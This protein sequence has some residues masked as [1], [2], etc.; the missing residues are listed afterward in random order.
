M[1]TD[2]VRFDRVPSEHDEGGFALIMSVVIATVCLILVTSILAMGLHLDSA[3]FRERR[4]QMALQVAEGGVERAVAEVN[5]AAVDDPDA[6]IG[7][8]IATGAGEHP[9]PIDIPGGQFASNVTALAG[10]AGF[11]VDAVG[12]VPD[13]TSPN[14]LMRR[15]RVTFE[16][17]PSFKY[18]LFS[19]TGIEVK[20]DNNQ[21]INGDIFANDD[22]VV[23]QNAEINGSVI[24][25]SGS[26]HIAE[27]VRIQ[28]ATDGTGGSVYSGGVHPADSGPG[29][30]PWGVRLDGNTL[31]ENEVHVQVPT[32]PCS[33]PSENDYNLKFGGNG[34]VVGGSVFVPGSVNGT[35][36][37]GS[38]DDDACEQAFGVTSLPEFTYQESAYPG[39]Q[40]VD[41]DDFTGTVSGYMYVDDLND[42]DAEI[43][44]CSVNG[45]AGDVVLITEARLVRT[46]SCGTFYTGPTD[47]T[48][49]LIVLN[50]N[51]ET[52]TFGPSV[53][54][55][56]N[57][58]LPN[59][60]PA[61]LLYSQGYCDLGTTVINSGAIYCNGLEVQT[62]MYLSYD[63]RI[64]S[65]VGFGGVLFERAA[66]RE[67]IASTPI[68]VTT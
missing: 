59:P 61:L 24:S 41:W 33:S 67:L 22:I 48:I 38:V 57:F 42:P 16:P 54:L 46:N 32:P 39:I 3:T 40:K 23:A 5:R 31:V 15:I 4:W 18:A 6:P 9:T 12:Y 14:R 35:G 27:N 62:N 64:R 66:F 44:L 65:L 30:R 43:D 2:V 21:P 17:E 50:D 52:A 11:Q 7:D 47:R 49:Q 51:G 60:S 68:T 25:A 1:S 29:E 19:N 58:D 45:T 28:E 63:P 55:G 8:V 37:T 26:V 34:V 20:N 56:N 13:A 36:T 10:G 53:Q